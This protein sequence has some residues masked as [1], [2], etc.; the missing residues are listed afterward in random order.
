MRNEVARLKDALAEKNNVEEDILMM[1]LINGRTME[2]NS[3]KNVARSWTRRTG[4]WQK[5][6]A[7]QKDPSQKWQV[8]SRQKS[9]PV[10]QLRDRLLALMRQPEVARVL[11]TMLRAAPQCRDAQSQ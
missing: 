2:E 8:R 4:Q 3:K 10:G 11:L 5:E 7:E 9:N 1:D 6:K